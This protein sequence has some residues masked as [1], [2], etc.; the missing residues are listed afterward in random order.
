LPKAR[1][2]KANSLKAKLISSESPGA[3]LAIL[4]LLSITNGRF[5]PANFAFTLAE[6]AGLG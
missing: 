4:L 2:P 5:R 3:D 1:C 6:I